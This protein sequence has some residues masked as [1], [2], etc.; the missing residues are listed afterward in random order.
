MA[1]GEKD[2][3]KD[4]ATLENVNTNIVTMC[5]TLNSIDKNQS[6][7]TATLSMMRNDYNKIIYALIGVIAASLGLKFIN[8]PWYVDVAV[9]ICELTGVF[10]FFHLISVW[11]TLN[12]ANRILRILLVVI[13]LF[14]SVVQ[15]IVYHPV[16]EPAPT[17]FIFAVNILLILLAGSSLWAVWVHKPKVPPAKTQEGECKDAS[18]AGKTRS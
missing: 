18:T 15:T 4:Q 11:K 10:V 13:M 3:K 5:N 7:Q 6:V 9:F 8:T 16:E 14:S 17:W 1:P 12:L 2:E